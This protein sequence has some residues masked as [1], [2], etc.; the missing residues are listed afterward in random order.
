MK[1]QNVLTQHQIATYLQ[2][3]DEAGSV[4]LKGSREERRAEFRAIRAA[5]RDREESQDDKNI[6]IAR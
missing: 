5:D 4:Q 3:S 6:Y 2:E 1:N